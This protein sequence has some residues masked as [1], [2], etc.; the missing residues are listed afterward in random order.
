MRWA[1]SNTSEIVVPNY[2]IGRWECD[3]LKISRS[4]HL[5][6]YEVKTSRS[7]FKNDFNKAKLHWGT[8]E[9]VETKFDNLRSG[10]RVNRF[11][12]V[13]P[14]GLVSKEEVPAGFGLI[15]ARQFGQYITFDIVKVA[16]LL[17]KEPAQA[18]LYKHIAQNL[19]VKLANAKAKKI[20]LPKTP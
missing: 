3:V 11:Y 12:Y 19:S 15:Y 6:E 1:A 5:Y 4:G 14:H 20:L 13:V 17:K 10:K 2:Y 7:D 9:V 8:S 16:S 18:G